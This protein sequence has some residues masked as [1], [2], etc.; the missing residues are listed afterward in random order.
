VL[1]DLISVGAGID[2]QERPVTP[3]QVGRPLAELHV[4]TPVLGVVRGEE[5]L[6]WDDD[7]AA[8]LQPGDKL[9]CLCAN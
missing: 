6:R 1:E 9:V 2:L 4:E 8:R 3:D 5:L 7:R